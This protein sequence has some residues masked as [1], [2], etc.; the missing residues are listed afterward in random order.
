ML[1]R[2]TNTPT[3]TAIKAQPEDPKARIERLVS[4]LPRSG[5]STAAFA[6]KHGVPPWKLYNARQVSTGRKRQR[7]RTK[8][9][10]LVPVRLQDVTDDRGVPLELVLS[11]GHRLLIPGNFNEQALRRLMGVLAGC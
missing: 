4:E 9:T 10:E 6:R 8:R 3:A 11:G 2:M 5:L 1:W 7:K